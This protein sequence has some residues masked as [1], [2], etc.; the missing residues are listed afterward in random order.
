MLQINHTKKYALFGAAALLLWLH[1]VTEFLNSAYAATHTLPMVVEGSLNL[2]ILVAMLLLVRCVA[3]VFSK[4]PLLRASERGL[5]LHLGSKNKGVVPWSVITGFRLSPDGQSVRLYL[6]RI[7]DTPERCAERF[8]IQTDERGQL[9]IS[10]RLRRK[11]GNLEGVCK[12]LETWREQFSQGAK[13][14]TCF[15]TDEAAQRK[16]A[17]N[18]K[19]GVS[20]V[21]AILYVLRAKYWSLV[22]ILY[23]L[24]AAIL[25]EHFDLSVQRT[26]FATALPF[27]IVVWL[28]RRLLNRGITALEHYK[29]SLAQRSVGL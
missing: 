1:S 5:Y 15:E 24:L 14:G 10:L 27:L 25:T 19:H 26:L 28:L 6:R 12:T 4:R 16:S 29:Q 21:L 9:M 7:W 18:N 11:T 22:L 20:A 3:L 2:S 17:A 23:L 8:N 13:Y